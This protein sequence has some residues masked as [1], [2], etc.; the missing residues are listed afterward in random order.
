MKTQRVLRPALF[1][2][3][4]VAVT[5]CNS[6]PSLETS[7]LTPLQI[8][9]IETRNYDS[10]DSK[11]MLKAVLNVLQ[12]EGFLVDDGNTDLGLLH[13]SRTLGGATTEKTFG[14]AI[15][16]FGVRTRRTPG[17]LLTIEA[18]ANVSE[19]GNQT[20][21]RLNFQRRDS[22]LLFTGP[23]ANSAVGDP[24]R[25]TTATPVTDPRIYQE[26]FAKVDRG[27]FIQKQGL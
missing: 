11:G 6:V 2:F 1:I 15:E 25:I 4:T 12:D 20:K 13:A 8:R 3:L 24:Y 22:S 7:Q 18:T 26:F 17:S 14:A 10:Q 21:V 9:A 5:G 27:L 23:N 16:L 19:F